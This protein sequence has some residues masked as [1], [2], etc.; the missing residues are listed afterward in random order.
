MQNQP[1]DDQHEHLP[2]IKNLLGLQASDKINGSGRD[3]EALG[4]SGDQS[5]SN[6]AVNSLGHQ[7]QQSLQENNFN[8]FNSGSGN[9]D[10]NL[11]PDAETGGLHSQT[12]QNSELAFNN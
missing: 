9:F 3:G 8:V 1:N 4:E 2:I 5:E 10:N 6:N 11:M 7:K 12:Q